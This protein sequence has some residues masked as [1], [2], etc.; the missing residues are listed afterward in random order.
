MAWGTKTQIITAQSVGGTEVFSS[1]V[2][3]TPGEI[4][5]IQVKADF[6]ASPTDHLEVRVYGTLDDSSE[7]SDTQ[8]ALATVIVNTDDPA[9]KSFPISGFVKF[10]LG[11]IRDGTTDTI[12][13]DAW[14]RK[15]G[16]DLGA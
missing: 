10:R 2:S 8:S 5:Q 13:V 9:Y 1:W 4:A 6:P 15:D 12:D 11:V 16:V 7:V 3:L 14:V